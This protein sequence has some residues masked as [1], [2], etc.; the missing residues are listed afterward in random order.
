MIFIL[1]PILKPVGMPN[2]N[3]IHPENGSARINK[4]LR[5][6]SINTKAFQIL[7]KLKFIPGSLWY[8]HNKPAYGSS[9][10]RNLG[11]Q[12]G[13]A[14]RYTYMGSDLIILVHGFIQ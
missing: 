14:V 8:Q 7:N 11:H 6:K 2:I 1:C 10:W 9:Y 13:N 12:F 5:V 3:T 4:A